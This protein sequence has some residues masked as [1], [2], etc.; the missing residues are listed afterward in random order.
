[1]IPVTDFAGK[2]VAVFGLGRTGLSAALA[3][4]AGGAFPIVG[5][6]SPKGRERAREKGLVAVDLI[7]VDW[8]RFIALVLSP[9]VPL[10]HPKPHPVVEK[11]LENQIPI[12]GDVELF[13]MALGPRGR[14]KAKVIAITGTNGKSTTTALIGHILQRNGFDAR[15]GGN[16]GAPV[17]SMEPPGD[18]TIYVLELSSFQ[19]DL[20]FTLSP[21]VSVLINVSQDHLDRHGSMGAYAAVKARILNGQL[22]G[23]LAVMG[24]DDEH[25]MA[26]YDFACERYAPEGVAVTPVSVTRALESGVYVQDGQLHD[27]DQPGAPVIADLTRMPSL[28]GIHNWQNAAVAAAALRRFLPD[29]QRLSAGLVSF[30]G[31]AHRMEQVATIDGVRFVNDS[32]ATNADAAARALACYDAI[33]WIAGGRAKDG[34]IDALTGLMPAVRKAYLIGEAGPAFERT[35]AGHAD[36]V[37]LETLDRAVAAAFA[38]ARQNNGARPVVLF[39]PACASF[40]QYPNFEARGDA[41]RALV[42]ALEQAVGPKPKSP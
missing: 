11:A 35:L 20:T 7:D 18:N 5:D 38:D 23:D 28:P 34:G 29:P 3:L 16:I 9:G 33:Y 4:K 26:I 40:D 37:V 30:P 32:K 41:F 24:V 1:M 39:S 15:V 42:R 19:L 17:L 13:S 21:D 22:D 25:C 6:D 12:I 36:T 14:R 10:T 31:L 2:E 27:A 8:T